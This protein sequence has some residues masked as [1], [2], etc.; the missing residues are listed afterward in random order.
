MQFSDEV[1]WGP[2]DFAVMGTLL[3]GT[4]LLY[5][6]V[7]SKLNVRKQRIIAGAVI[8][9]GLLVFWVHIAVGIVDSWPLAGS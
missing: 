2:L 5:E 7:M 4:G 9:I 3:I 6:F 8:L 1:K